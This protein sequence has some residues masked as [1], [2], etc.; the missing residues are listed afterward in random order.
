MDNNLLFSNKHIWID[1]KGDT[2][3]LGIT[4][5]AQS[6]LG[7]IMF[8]N[9]P[10]I[11]ERVECNE[12][13]GDIE[14]VKTVSDLISP[15]SGEVVSVNEELMDEPESINEAPFKS[16]FVEVKVESRIDDLMDEKTYN[17]HKGEF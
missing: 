12:R 10:D 15:V 4:D 8:I 7:A 13:F 5:H 9:L 14:S 3:L 6:R 16:W 1:D 17:T 2:A 11:G